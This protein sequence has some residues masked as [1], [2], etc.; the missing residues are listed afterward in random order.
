M[1]AENNLTVKLA[2]CELL[3]NIF[4]SGIN[5]NELMKSEQISL[6]RH[7]LIGIL[8][9]TLP[10]Y[11]K[12]WRN[13]GSNQRALVEKKTIYPPL[14]VKKIRNLIWATFYPSR[15]E[16]SELF[17]FFEGR[18]DDYKDYLDSLIGPNEGDNN[19]QESINSWFTCTAAKK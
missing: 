6:N 19:I 16:K 13:H 2:A 15:K 14:L 4:G 18:V 8:Y 1:T 3:T 9:L 10:I 11:D 12:R 17:N 5:M 7:F